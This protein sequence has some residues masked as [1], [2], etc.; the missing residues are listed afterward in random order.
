[1]TPLALLLLVTVTGW[2]LRVGRALSAAWMFAGFAEL[3]TNCPVT[4]TYAH[5]HTHTHA[6][7]RKHIKTIACTQL[8]HCYKKCIWSK[9]MN[10]ESYF[11]FVVVYFI[12][13]EGDE[14]T[15]TDCHGHCHHLAAPHIKSV[16]RRQTTTAVSA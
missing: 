8:S 7:A 9:N 4:R 3:G 1:M 10:P 11:T 6:H 12:G 14:L 5:T 15:E 16:S 2:S 13:N